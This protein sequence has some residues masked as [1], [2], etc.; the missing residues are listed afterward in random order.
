MCVSGSLNCLRFCGWLSKH[1][2]DHTAETGEDAAEV[3]VMRLKAV[4]GSS[5]LGSFVDLYCGWLQEERGCK[6]ST[7]ANYIQA[8]RERGNPSRAT[9]A[10]AASSICMTLCARSTRCVCL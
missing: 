10:A 3:P 2:E 5:E 8:R 7:I 4:Y 9:A 6:Y 1:Y